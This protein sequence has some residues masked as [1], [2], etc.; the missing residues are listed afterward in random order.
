MKKIAKILS[1]LIVVTILF[2][3]CASASTSS[4]TSKTVAPA[5]SSTAATSAVKKIKVAVCL[6]AL[7]GD[8]SFNDSC[9]VGV[10]KAIADF[11]ANKVEVKFSE[12]KSTADW[13]PNLIAAASGDYDLIIV[14]SGQQKDVLAKVA[15]QFPNKKFGAIDI[16]LPNVPNVM[17][18]IFAQN[19]GSFLAGAAAAMFTTKTDIPNVNKEKIVGWV[20]GKDIP[21]LQDF[22]LGFK[23]GVA[24]IDPEIK[25]LTSFAGSFSDP[26]KGKELTLAQYSQGADIVM[27]VASGTGTGIL[28]AAAESK[29]YAIGVDLNQDAIKPGYILTSMLKNVD[30]ASYAFIKKVLEGTFDGGKLMYMNVK[31]GGVGLTDFSVMKTALGSKFPQDIVDKCKIISGKIASGEIK[32]SEFPGVR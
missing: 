20:G 12:S 28:E 22:L 6:A 5:S 15:P 21:I 16:S 3:A 17:S 1:L 26:L 27:N 13:E 4:S 18:T 11:G 8:K 7:L 14:M 9:K 2:T 29:K 19:E 31:S 24:Y 10:D 30:Q 25:V 23:E 32:V